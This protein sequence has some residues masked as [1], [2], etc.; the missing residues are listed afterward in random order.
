[1][2]ARAVSLPGTKKAVSVLVILFILTFDLPRAFGGETLSLE[3]LLT[4]AGRNSETVQ[5]VD[6][7]IQSIESD[8]SSRDLLLSPQIN[9]DLASTYDS[10]STLSPS[11]RFHAQLLEVSLTKLFSTGT[12][13]SFTGGHQI[14]DLSTSDSTAAGTR[15]IGEWEVRLSQALW[16]GAFG[17]DTRLRHNSEEAELKSRTIGALTTR[18]NFFMNLESVYWDLALALKQEQIQKTTIQLSKT[19]EK[20]TRDR[21]NRFNA[22]PTDLLQAQ[23]LVSN[24][25][26]S[27]I[28]IRNTIAALKNQLRELIPNFDPSAWTLNL[29]SLE[30]DRPLES[31]MLSSAGSNEPVRLDTLTSIYSARQAE[32]D[33]ARIDDS[34]RPKLDAYVSYGQNG[35]DERFGPAWNNA[36]DPSFSSARVGVALSVDLDWRLKNDRRRAAELNAQSL[37]LQAQARKRSSE[38]GWSDLQRQVTELR[39]QVKEARRLA[40][41]QTCK[42]DAERRRYRLGRTTVFQLITFE[43]DA[44]EAELQVYRLL[45]DLRKVE[46]R[47]RLFTRW[48]DGV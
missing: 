15:N 9:A 31:L 27:L 14:T 8:I 7:S 20:W 17:R 2:R 36:A 28:G 30:D 33:A 21:V 5:A 37:T 46:S 22:E 24:R 6:K 11:K 40:D 29:N 34:L 3:D 4:L 43:V 41:F 44:T 1:M 12:T 35:S 25:E 39:A 45:A 19:V 10:R 32:V 18:Q 26:L 42:A 23:A 13:L 38:V 48:Q 47:A 16:R